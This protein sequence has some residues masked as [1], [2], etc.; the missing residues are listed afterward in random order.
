MFSMQPAPNE[1]GAASCDGVAD[2]PHDP[3]GS[4]DCGGTQPPGSDLTQGPG[5]GGDSDGS[6]GPGPASPGAPGG[7]PNGGIDGGG[8]PSSPGGGGAPGAPTGYPSGPTSPGAGAPGAPGDGGGGGQGPRSPRELWEIRA[9]LARQAAVNVATMELQRTEIFGVFPDFEIAATY[10]S[11]LPVQRGLAGGI[12][13]RWFHEFQ[14]RLEWVNGASQSGAS[15][16]GGSSSASSLPEQSGIVHRTRQQPHVDY[17]WMY[18]D[19]G[20][21]VYEGPAHLGRTIETVTQSPWPSAAYKLIFKDGRAHYFDDAGRLVAR[22]GASGVDAVVLTYGGTNGALSSITDTAGQAYVVGSDATG[23]FVTSVTDPLG[24][25]IT[26]NVDTSTDRLLSATSPS[27]PVHSNSLNTSGAPIASAWSSAVSASTTRTYLYNGFSRLQNVLQDNQAVDLD[28][29]YQTDDPSNANPSAGVVW[30][31]VDAAGGQWSFELNGSLRTVT[32]PRGF[33]R[34][35]MVDASNQVIRIREYLAS[36]NPNTPSRATTGHRDWQITRNAACQCGLIDSISEPDGTSW[37]IGYDAEFNLEEVVRVPND[38]STDRLRNS[39]VYDSVGRLH[40]Y[41]PAEAHAAANPADY[42]YTTTY[43]DL[44]ANHPLAPNGIERVVSTPA[45]GLHASAPTWISRYDSR[46]RLVEV[47][48]PAIDGGQAG[49]YARY[50]YY[51]AGNSGASNRLK[52][53]YSRRD[54]SVWSQYGYDAVGRLVSVTT[55]TGHTMALTLDSQGRVSQWLGPHRGSQQYAIEFLYD[56]QGRLSAKRYR[57]YDRGPTPTGTDPYTWVEQSYWYD[58]G[59]RVLFVENDVDVGVRSREAFGYDAA[60]NLTDYTDPDGRKTHTVFDERDLEWKLYGGYQTPEQT[61]AIVDYAPSG[62]MLTRRYPLNGV[63]VVQEVTYDKFGRFKSV[64]VAG[65]NLVEVGYDGA[66]RASTIDT[67][68][69]AAGVL[70]LLERESLVY[71]DWHDGPTLRTHYV[72]DQDGLNLVRTTVTEIEYAPFGQ[73]VTLTLDGEVLARFEYDQNGAAKRIFDDLG[74]AEEIIRDNL[75]GYVV[76]HKLTQIDRVHQA[77]GVIERQ[78]ERDPAGRCTKTIYVAPGQPNLF[79]TSEYDSLDNVV[80]HVDTKG[81]VTKSRHR[82]DG[83]Q[84]ELM[85]DFDAVTASAASTQTYGYLPSGLLQTIT[86]NRQNT[87]TWVFDAHGRKTREIQADATFWEWSYNDGGFLS[88]ITTPTGRVVDLDYDN[89]GHVVGRTIRA[90]LG[91]AV[92]RT[93]V[94][95]WTMSGHLRLANKSEG[96]STTWTQFTRQGDGRVLSESTDGVTVQYLRDSLGRVTQLSGPNIVQNYQYDHYN[97]VST[98]RDSSNVLAR[99]W[100]YG[101]GNALSRLQLGDRTRTDLYRD[102]YGRLINTTTVRNSTQLFEYDYTWDV[103][104]TLREEFRDHDQLGDG[105]AYDD[106]KRLQTFVRASTAPLQ[107]LGAPGSTTHLERIQYS[108]DGDH[109]RSSVTRT[110]FQGA[111]VATNYVT[112]PTRHHYSSI[113]GVTRTMNVDGNVTAFGARSFEYDSTDNLARVQDSGATVATYK[114]DALGRRA[115]KTVG[116]TTTSFVNAGPWVVEEHQSIGG[117]ASTLVASNFYMSGIDDVV[118]SRRLDTADLDQDGSTADY[119]DLYFHK[120]HQGSVMHL[121]LPTGTIVESYRY[122]SYGAP[123]IMDRTGQVVSAAPS[124]NRFMFTGREFDAETGLYH[125][126]ARTYDPA[127]GTFLQEDPLGL[128]DGVNPVAYVA[129]NPVTMFDPTGMSGI[130]DALQSITEFVKNN[131]DLAVELMKEVLPPLG[132]I[133]DALEAATGYNITGWISSGFKVLADLTWFERAMAA[134]S[135]VVALGGAVAILAKLDDILALMK[136]IKDRAAKAAEEAADAARAGWNKLTGACPNGCFASGTLVMVACGGFV[137]IEQLELGTLVACVE[138]EEV[139]DASIRREL[140]IADENDSLMCGEVQLTNEHGTPVRVQLLRSESWWSERVTGDGAIWLE[141]AEMGV[142]GPGVVARTWAYSGQLDLGTVGARPV[143]GL[144]VTDD[145]PTLRVTLDDGSSIEATGDHPFWSNTRRAW[146][147]AV[148]LVRGEELD[149]A[150]GS[151]RVAQVVGTGKQSQVFNCEVAG[152]HSYRAGT[153]GALVHNSCPNPNG[154]KGKPDHQ[155]KVDELFKKAQGEAGPD[156]TVLRERR[157][158][159]V[160][161]NRQPDV[162]IVDPN[163]RTRK[164]FEAERRPGSKRNRE[165]EAEYR[166][167]NV[168]FETHG[169]D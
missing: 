18:V 165:R 11:Q 26:F 30:K 49:P 17:D 10:Y 50:E 137:P 150:S 78:F 157:V 148:A 68:G 67:F 144:F 16:A 42:T 27:R 23:T 167:L 51:P 1:S 80:R 134:G 6:G 70:R 166:R 53:W 47:E 135:A 126:R 2:G 159:G 92:L 95:D 155:A 99:A 79:E 121:T 154:A 28:V 118:M 7:P 100:Y 87:V 22:V 156:E 119:V 151:T 143:T 132:L 45:G 124:G 90:S 114:Y 117:G 136:K 109:H 39:L 20:S 120:N 76:G 85:R 57:Y 72:Y 123:T 163:G 127:N 5:P 41:I 74:S 37:E 29:K 96:G 8:G 9:F 128:A 12:G 33:Q 56:W 89:R 129:A 65:A 93:D 19:N 152:A 64:G 61:L 169:L 24:K 111:P 105:Y 103:D 101:P 38:Q 140:G 83:A 58:N 71:E 62:G 147:P 73:P 130:G 36:I 14:E 82:F 98:L 13:A 15:P 160:A 66:S 54:L 69:R 59:G 91:G 40:K 60:S 131:A 142:D 32:E 63:D 107:E 115:S 162:Q 104:G 138:A 4:N 139:S 34:E 145:A 106:L 108:L 3:Q 149:V 52:R 44:P 113:G 75:S 46:R 81:V 35:Y 77:P 164:V 141:L 161:S 122:D 43:V 146:V 21:G 110:P 133:I 97:R 94:Y 168:E 84:V 102:G 86:D 55:N 125:Y 88:R 158:Q 48:E 153:A 116:A 25:T 31:I 112:H